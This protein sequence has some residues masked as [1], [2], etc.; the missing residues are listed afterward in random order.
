M[1]TLA[2]SERPAAPT[3]DIPLSTVSRL[4]RRIHMFTGLFLAPWMLMYALST[5]VMTHREYVLSFYPSKSPAMVTDR[6]LDYT[7]SF[8]T[9]AT[10]EQIAQQILR[11][12]GLDGAHSVGGGR[13]GKPLVIQRQHALPQQRITFDAKQ[14][15]ILIEREEFRGLTFLERMHRRRG[16]N[17][18]YALDDTWG[19]TVDVAVV[20]M[21]FWSLS[22][23]WLWWE[24]KTTR[25]WGALSLT[26]GLALFAIFLSLL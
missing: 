4:I 7:H 1:S 26:A 15:K 16:Y 3:T 2:A 19:F 24:L 21:V 23:I 9:N 25:G 18:P 20:T 8:P 6:Q 13:N 12:L 17:Q 22:G 10:R 14:N 5:L 11:D